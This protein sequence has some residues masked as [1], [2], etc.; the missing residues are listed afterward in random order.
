MAH[1][2]SWVDLS[3][4]TV[5]ASGVGDTLKSK[6]DVEVCLRASESSSGGIL[7]KP[8]ELARRLL[9]EGATAADKQSPSP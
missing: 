6:V 8:V 2:V 7:A 9:I 5:Q 1:E 3:V 4:G